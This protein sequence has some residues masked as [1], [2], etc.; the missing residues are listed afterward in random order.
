MKNRFIIRYWVA[1]KKYTKNIVLPT[2]EAVTKDISYWRNSIFYSILTNMAPLSM[3]ALVPSIYM[4]LM[5]GLAVVAVADIAAFFLVLALMTSRRLLL[6]QRKII[7]IGIIYCLSAIL[8]YFLSVPGPGFLFLLAIVVIAAIIYPGLSAYTW[9]FI[10]T[11]ICLIFAVL[12]GLKAPIPATSYYSTGGWVAISSNLVLLSFVCAQ[13]LKL[14]LRGLETYIRKKEDIETNLTAIFENTSEG[15]ILTDLKGN[16]KS[17]NN[18]SKS[19]IFQNTGKQ[20]TTGSSILDYVDASRTS[21]YKG[22]FVAI[23]A[24]KTLQYDYPFLRKNG[25]TKWFSFSVN[26]VYHTGVID[27]ICITTADVTE[28]NEAARQL[29]ESEQFNKAILASLSAHIAVLGEN[30]NIIAVNKAWEDFAKANGATAFSRESKGTNYLDVCKSA[31]ASGE[32]GAADILAGIQAV[33]QRQRHSFEAEYPCHSPNEQRWFMLNV[34]NF[35]DDRSKVVISHQDVTKRKVAEEQLRI[36]RANLEALVENTDASIYSLDRNFR[37]I[38]FNQLLANSMQQAFGLQ[39]KLGDRVY[40]FLE[41]LDPAEAREW[42]NIYTRA[43]TGEIIK[44]EKTFQIANGSTSYVSFSIHPIWEQQTV[45]GLSCY[46]LDITKQKNAQ[47]ELL[48]VHQ[49]K[50]SILESIDDAFFAVDKNWIVTYWNK[51][52]ENAIN[53]PKQNIIGKN[54]WEVLPDS[55]NSLSYKKYHEAMESAQGVNFED[56]FP[57]RDKWF[58]VT[59]YPSA[60]GLSI[61]FVDITERKNDIA[62]KA[63]Y[64]QTIE[65]QNKKFREIAFMQSHI[66]RAPLATMMGLIYLIKD[67]EPE[68][69]ELREFLDNILLS[70][71][72]LDQVIREISNKTELV[73][74]DA[75]LEMPRQTSV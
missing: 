74:L 68:K 30:G 21:V 52:A 26:P 17:F 73:D 62:I 11:G 55:T 5:S 38:T 6:H 67:V 61:Y 69:E 65:A 40:E 7:F 60:T 45:T 39:I 48:K 47:I 64:L 56:Y 24:G 49:E 14:L 13:C 12:I 2:D 3:I 23:M 43:F 1:Y 71:D 15:F 41:K 66:V 35:G 70:A 19:I 44:F 42:E 36:S 33:F 58:D 29:Q 34:M 54:L 28:R 27:G 53:L 32:E 75:H 37:Y 51:E 57:P 59:V 8:L 63:Q 25:E 31:V 18:K 22:A 4:S 9:A 46:A 20:L 10:N 50:N 16:V 72:R